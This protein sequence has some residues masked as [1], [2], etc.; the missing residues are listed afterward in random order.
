[1]TNGSANRLLA[2][3]PEVRIATKGSHTHLV[4][5]GRDEILAGRVQ[6][7]V[8]QDGIGVELEVL[9]L[10]SVGGIVQEDL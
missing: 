8:A 2:A 10:D 4:G 6:M 3:L 5:R 7:E 1:M 9:E